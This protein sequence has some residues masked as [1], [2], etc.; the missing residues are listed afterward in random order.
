MRRDA[1]FF[2]D[3]ELDLLHMAR[4]LRDA[5]RLEDLLTAAGI[6]YLIETGTYTG[7]LLMR[8]DLTGAFFYVAPG[9]LQSARK[10]LVSNGYKP[11]EGD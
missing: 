7:G 4:R 9:A 3:A 5:L 2:G 11:Y 8:R 1:E 6:D 10:L